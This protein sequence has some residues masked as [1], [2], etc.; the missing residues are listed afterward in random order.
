MKITNRAMLAGI[1]AGASFGAAPAMAQNSILTFGFTEMNGSY[2][3]ATSHF[4]ANAVATAPL[5]TSGD[6]TRLVAPSNTA[7]YNPGTASGLVGVDLLVSGVVGNTANGAGNL[8]ITDANGD[9]LNATISGQFIS[10][11]PAVFFNGLLS[12]IF[13][14]DN[15]A[16]DGQFDGPSGGSFPLTFQPVPPP[17]SGAIVQLYIGNAG[18]FFTQS[19]SGISTQVSGAIV[20]TPASLSVLGLG[21]LAARRRRRAY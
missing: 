2:S 14:T 17:Y 8:V 4:M 16:Q 7:L 1:V 20:P 19:F 13:F 3:T 6:V 21:A 9:T 5:M 12:N 18:A 15:G 10:N 11:G